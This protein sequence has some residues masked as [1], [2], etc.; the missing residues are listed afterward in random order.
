MLV[1]ATLQSIAA[2]FILGKTWK[3]P[4]YLSEGEWI[5]RGALNLYLLSAKA[6]LKE[7][8]TI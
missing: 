8:H 6:N 2:I 4:R 1:P 7:L 5:N 3:P